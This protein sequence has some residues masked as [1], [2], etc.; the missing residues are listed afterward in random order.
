MFTAKGVATFGAIAVFGAVSATVLA[1]PA[2]AEKKFS[3]TAISVSTMVVGWS[4]GYPAE[5]GVGPNAAGAQRA[6]QECANHPL[7]PSDCRWLVSGPCVALTAN[8]DRYNSGYAETRK[9]AINKAQF[10]GWAKVTSVC[11]KS[12]TQPQGGSDLALED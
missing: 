9:E 3:A 7:H 12:T 6:T 8:P 2:S 4:M 11:S 10:P 1:P 5:M